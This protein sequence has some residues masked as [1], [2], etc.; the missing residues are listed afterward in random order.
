MVVTSTPLYINCRLIRGSDPPAAHGVPHETGARTIPAMRASSAE[1][2]VTQGPSPPPGEGHL[3]K[4]K[5][6]NI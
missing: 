1:V 6:E 4:T 2:G 5:K 3:P